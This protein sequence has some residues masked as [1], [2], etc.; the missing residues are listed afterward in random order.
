L[1][2]NIERIVCRVSEVVYRP[3]M[4]PIRLTA[5]SHGSG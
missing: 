1:V 5:F 2:V 4:E 3:L